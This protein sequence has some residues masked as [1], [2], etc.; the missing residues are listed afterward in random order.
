MKAN[1]L[2]TTPVHSISSFFNDPIKKLSA[3]NFCQVIRTKLKMLTGVFIYKYI[4]NMKES[5]YFDIH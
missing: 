3:I 1:V 5:L 2:L 4:G